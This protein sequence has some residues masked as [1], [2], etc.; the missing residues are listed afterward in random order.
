VAKPKKARAKKVAEP[1]VATEPVAVTEAKPKKARAKKAD[2]DSESVS[3]VTKSPEYEYE[4]TDTVKGG[5]FMIHKVTKR[6]YRADLNQDGDKRALLD[7]DAGLF[8]DGD[9][10]P[11]FDD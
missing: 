2:A 7:Q 4:L 5:F 11:I 6:A 9:I 10:L 3:E 1:V 8:K